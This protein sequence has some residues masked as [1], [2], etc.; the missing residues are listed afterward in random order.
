[1][2]PLTGF[3]EYNVVPL[4]HIEVLPTIE[5]GAIIGAVTLMESV[6]CGDVPQKLV[7]ST[8]KVPPVGPAVTVI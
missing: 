7:P 4:A 8:V 2:A 1:M 3:T 5:A 6:A